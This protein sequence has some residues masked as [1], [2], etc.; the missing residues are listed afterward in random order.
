[1][2]PWDRRIGAQSTPQRIPAR[3]TTVMRTE[4]ASL[5]APHCV[6]V[7]QLTRS[8]GNAC[9][10]SRRNTLQTRY[11]GVG[12]AYTSVRQ[13]TFAIHLVQS[14]A[15]L[16]HVDVRLG[17][18]R[19]TSRKRPSPARISGLAAPLFLS[20]PTSRPGRPHNVG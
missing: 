11:V 2:I 9:L 3:P 4:T 19:K 17:E 1:M 20:F 7:E 15:P 18:R 6:R 10:V 14:T 13:R 16:L 5:S 12:G 8:R